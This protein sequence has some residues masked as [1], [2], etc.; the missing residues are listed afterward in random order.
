MAKPLPGLVTAAGRRGIGWERGWWLLKQYRPQLLARI[1][2]VPAGWDPSDDA[3]FLTVRESLF[4]VRRKRQGVA[5]D[6]F[7]SEPMSNTF[8]LEDIHVPTLL[9]H[10]ADDPLAPYEHAPKA[11]AR[12]PGA[13]LVTVPVGGHLFLQHQAEV[14]QAA[15][16][17]IAEC[18]AVST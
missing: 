14:R 5:F 15:Q 2:G 17:F 4:P 3:F 18:T 11:A 16:L 6:G 8:P 1:M 7:V 13:R 9:V 12:I 10:A